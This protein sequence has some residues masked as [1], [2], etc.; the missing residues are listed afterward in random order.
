[1]W[2]LSWGLWIELHKISEEEVDNICK[3][4]NSLV[5][6]KIDVK[7]QGLPYVTSIVPNKESYLEPDPAPFEVSGKLSICFIVEDQAHRESSL[8]L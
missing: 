4:H 2:K 6:W 7:K 1:M 3:G 5:T 8:S